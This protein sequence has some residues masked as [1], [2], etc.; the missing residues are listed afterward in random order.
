MEFVDKNKYRTQPALTF[1]LDQ[2]QKLW[3]IHNINCDASAALY[4]RQ[5]ISLTV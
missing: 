4:H 5:Y 2:E 1:K 3:G